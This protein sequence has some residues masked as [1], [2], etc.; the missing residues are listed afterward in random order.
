M[1][2]FSLVEFGAMPFPWS[3]PWLLASCGLGLLAFSSWHPSWW[4]PTGLT[5]S[6]ES[7]FFNKLGGSPDRV[8]AFAIPLSSS[9]RGDGQEKELQSVC[10]FFRSGEQGSVKFAAVFGSASSAAFRRPRA[11]LP[12]T[13]MAEWQPLRALAPA[14]CCC[15]LFFNLQAVEPSR[16]P[17]TSFHAAFIICSTPSGVIPGGVVGGRSRK[18]Q[19]DAG[20]EGSVWKF[21]LCSRILFV[22]SEDCAA[23]LLFYKVLFVF[24]KPTDGN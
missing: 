24:C 5:G 23:F 10:G 13:S 16:R 12:L 6:G 11:G 19:I 1:Q 8:R 9:H 18:L 4:R 22:I 21:H 17:F 2:L 15:Y 14:A 3:F 7:S 20:G